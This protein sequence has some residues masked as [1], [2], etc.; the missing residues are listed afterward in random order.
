MQAALYNTT[1]E[2]TYT[3]YLVRDESDVR[4]LDERDSED[5]A[6]IH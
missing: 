1:A 2:R 3:Y 4:E 6:K 5:N